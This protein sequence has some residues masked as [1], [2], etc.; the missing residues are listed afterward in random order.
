MKNPPLNWQVAVIC[1]IGRFKS[2]R[3]L[4]LLVGLCGVLQPVVALQD[5]N[6]PANFA[7]DHVSFNDINKTTIYA[8]HVRMDQGATHLIADQVMVYKNQ[9]GQMIKLVA[10]G[11]PAH[12]STLPDGQQKPLDA[13]GDRIDYY[14]LQRLAVITGNGYVTQAANSLNGPR[15]IYDM[16]KQTVTS[17]PSAGVNNQKSLIILQPQNLPGTARKPGSL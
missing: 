13:Y 8:G 2:W 1:L 4:A 14:P 16:V 12:Y 15:I 17:L 5:A 9:Q 11:K 6:Q 7:A 3:Q 10:S